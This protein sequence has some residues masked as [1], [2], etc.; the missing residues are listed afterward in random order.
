MEQGEMTPLDLARDM[1]HEEV[2]IL[3]IGDTG[4][5]VV[6]AI[7]DTTLGPAV[8]GTRMMKYPRFD[9]AILDALRLSRAMTYKAAMA[10]MSWGGAKA[11]IDGD[12]IID[13]TDLF[14]DAYAEALDRFGRFHTGGDMGIDA[15]DVTE[16]ARRTKRM[17]HV[18][19]EAGVSASGLT[20][21]GVREAIM[22]ASRSIRREPTTAIHVAIQGL[23]E[24]GWPLARML[25]T[26][27]IRL[28][29]TDTDPAR[30]SAAV[31]ELGASAVSPDA[32]YDV[33]A[34][35]FAPCAR[36]AVLNEDTI[37][38]LRCAAVVGAANEQLCDPQH[39]DLLNE[40]GI[41]YGPDYVV[42]AGG[43]LSLL[44]ERG[45][46]DEPGIVARVRQIGPRVA[47][48][49]REGQALGIPPHRLADRI[50]EDKLARARAKGAGR[51]GSAPVE[52]VG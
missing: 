25:A 28:T 47:N 2:C 18:P 21:I 1:R 40:L 13:K 9:D 42:N 7:H 6:I 23:G 37:P 16:L 27:G 38:R 50:V 12:P 10:E 35:V 51:T 26:D 20:A 14:Y 43:L 34:D 41:L 24:V 3:R 49:W 22:A 52:S 5:R 36:G 8:G 11:V 45:E 46:T 31:R 19:P 32:I 4:L 29:V 33:E 44:F 48:L 39:G 15:A 17:S 30:I